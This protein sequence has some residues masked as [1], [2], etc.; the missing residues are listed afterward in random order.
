MGQYIGRRLLLSIPGLLVVSLLI[1]FL[2]RV[3]PG[4]PVNFILGGSDP[5]SAGAIS[6][7]SKERLRHELGLDRPLVVQYVSWVGGFFKGDFGN[8]LSYN[9]PTTELL[10][11]ALP[12]SLELL[13]F[14]IFFS[15]VSGISLGFISAVTQD[16]AVDYVARVIS[17][18]FLA[19]PSF[20]VGLMIL[21]YPVLLFGFTLPLGYAK[22]WEEP[23]RNLQQFAP[24]GAVFGL[25]MAGALA[26]MTRSSLLE[27]LRQDYIRTARAKG[28]RE[29]V[30]MLRH[31]LKNA[32]IPVLS[33]A[34]IQMALLLGGMVVIES[35]FALPGVGR[36]L[37]QSLQQRDYILM[38]NLVL[39]LAIWVVVINLAVDLAYGLL[40][41][42]IRYQ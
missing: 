15:F 28:V 39:L 18:V 34:G 38:Q 16:T 35:L 5:A 9:S 2:M 19:V 14:A 42:R 24:T 1:F 40:D 21:V 27:V 32:M 8:S 3:I 30:V 29:R 17:I 20:W 13:A 23:I 36:L 12:V 4:D 22:L 11:N 33:I 31:A 37:I 41:P 6:E 10:K 26:R 25:S 7:E